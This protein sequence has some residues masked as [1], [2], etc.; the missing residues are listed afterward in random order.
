MDGP[1]FKIKSIILICMNCYPLDMV[2]YINTFVVD[3]VGLEIR[4]FCGGETW[5]K[6]MWG[7]TLLIG[8]FMMGIRICKKDI[9]IF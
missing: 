7:V 1:S 2:I 4:V 6:M 5:W 8:G 3:F 9:Y